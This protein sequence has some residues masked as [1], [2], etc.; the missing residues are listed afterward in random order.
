[1]QAGQRLNKTVHRIAAEEAYSLCLERVRKKRDIAKP[2]P[3]LHNVDPVSIR[4]SLFEFGQ[5]FDFRVAQR[6]ADEIDIGSEVSDQ[7]LE[8]INEIE[9]RADVVRDVLPQ[10]IIPVERLSS[11]HGRDER[12]K[13]IVLGAA[14][15]AQFSDEPTK[16]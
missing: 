3:K 15:S 12:S 11:N 13:V 5:S 10:A 16:Q 1:M 7:S 9:I 6:A 2:R 8:K 4:V 14:P